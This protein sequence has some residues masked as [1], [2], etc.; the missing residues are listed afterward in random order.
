MFSP[1][2]VELDKSPNLCQLTLYNKS[3]ST[4]ELNYGILGTQS[5][6]DASRYGSWTIAFATDHGILNTTLPQFCSMG[7]H[8][9]VP[10]RTVLTRSKFALSDCGNI[11]SQKR[12]QNFWNGD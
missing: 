2:Q 6:D 5:D 8:T 11:F 12:I 9:A 10:T 3:M 4:F 1:L 7:I